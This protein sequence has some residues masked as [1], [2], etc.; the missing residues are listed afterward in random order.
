MFI[1]KASLHNYADDNTLSAFA[2]DIDDLIEIL[3]DESQETID[4]LKLNQMIVNP[5]KFQAMFI[6]KKKNALPRNLKL[7]I[8]NKEIAL[9]PSVE[10]LGVTIDNEL[11]FDQHISRLCKS[12]GCQLNAGAITKFKKSFGWIIDKFRLNNSLVIN[13]TI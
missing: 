2:T 7:Q 4:W 5:K 12:A 11:K 8:N 3:T 1:K 6:S 9:Q 13:G 10:L